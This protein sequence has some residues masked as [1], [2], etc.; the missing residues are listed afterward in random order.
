VSS[1]GA[2]RGAHPTVL[3][4]TEQRLT[5]AGGTWR[6]RSAITFLADLRRLGLKAAVL[7]RQDPKTAPRGMVVDADAVYPSAVLTLSHRLPL[8]MTSMMR[9]TWTA[10]GASSAVLAVVP[11]FMGPLA[12]A[13]ARARGRPVGVVVVGDPKQSLAPG[14]VQ[15]PARAVTRGVLTT[16]TRWA[17][18]HS[19][20]ALYVTTH[21]LQSRY[22]PRR[23]TAAYAA[24]NVGPVTLA[25]PRTWPGPG[26]LQLLTVASLDQ[27]YKGIDVLIEA[28]AQMRGAGVTAGLTVVGEGRLR[29][30]YSRL[31]GARLGDAVRFT[32][33]LGRDAIAQAYRDA[34]VFVLASLAEGLPRALIE[35]MGAGLPCVATDVGGVPELLPVCWMVPPRDPAALARTVRVL[36][37]DAQLYEVASR[38]NLERVGE[39]MN[40]NPQGVRREFL[41][42][43]LARARR[44]A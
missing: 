31:A 20:V 1:A 12:V 11:G 22:P 39:L 42:T 34:D 24:P 5:P 18:Q 44:G 43:L 32:G 6:S 37:E 8:Q 23:G 15:H 9:A 27:P 30:Q 16:T 29:P 2:R 21:T 10:V 7:A 14:A 40:A 26:P 25:N 38:R 19:D 33:E 13:F 36:V 28:V 4:T 3:L 41:E 17:C 35:A